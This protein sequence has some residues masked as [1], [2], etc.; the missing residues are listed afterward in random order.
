MAEAVT[1][2]ITTAQPEPEPEVL[3]D[4]VTTP[5]GASEPAE[6]VKPAV[7]RA[8]VYPTGTE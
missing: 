2:T 5:A 1:P 6:A 3:Q 8:A 4:T 7:S